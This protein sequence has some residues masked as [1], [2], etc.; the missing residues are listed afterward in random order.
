MPLPLCQNP[1]LAS[2]A[3]M[4]ESLSKHAWKTAL[5]PGGSYCYLQFF[6]C[7]RESWLGIGCLL[8]TIDS[9]M[10]QVMLG[11]IAKW[12]I[13]DFAKDIAS[14]VS[15]SPEPTKS[16]VWELFGG[17]RKT[18]APCWVTK[19]WFCSLK[20]DFP[21]ITLRLIGVSGWVIV[22][23]NGVRLLHESD[24]SW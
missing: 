10:Y 5:S 1:H 11:Y 2:S 17:W 3:C 19:I 20:D 24:L 8:D 14:C 18:L 6:L 12:G 23:S 13:L 22:H 7:I 9:I 4:C 16:F 21:L 15:P